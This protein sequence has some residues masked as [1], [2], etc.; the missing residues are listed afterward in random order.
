MYKEATTAFSFSGL[1]DTGKGIYPSCSACSLI[2][3]IIEKNKD[4]RFLIMHRSR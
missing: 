4:E 2:F 3:A 1:H